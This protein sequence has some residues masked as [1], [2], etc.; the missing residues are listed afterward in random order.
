M[1]TLTLNTDAVQKA[2]IK[3]LKT[4]LNMTVEGKEIAVSVI[5]G[6]KSADKPVPE[7]SATI[8][9]SD[10]TGA[11]VNKLNTDFSNKLSECSYVSTA[12]TEFE[13]VAE[14]CSEQPEPNEPSD[15]PCEPSDSA[16]EV[17]MA[18]DTSDVVLPPETP[19]TV[20][21]ESDAKQ[22]EEEKSSVSMF[23]N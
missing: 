17:V 11:S 20:F 6:R 8:S 4:D 13:Q 9:I 5:V 22:D 19:E 16:L 3:Y 1:I 15:E 21:N 14:T 10:S 12:E 23:G 2:L 18:E 7:V